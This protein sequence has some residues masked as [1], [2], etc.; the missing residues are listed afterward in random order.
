MVLSKSHFSQYTLSIWRMTCHCV[1]SLLKEARES[2]TMKL[3]TGAPWMPAP[4]YG[5]SL[6]GL[7]LNL[8]VRNI[9]AALP[10]HRA[11]LGAEVV[12]SDPDFAVLRYGE[13]GWMLHADH[14]Y[15]EHPLHPSL[16]EDGPR[17]VGAELRLHG[18]DPDDDE[19][20]YGGPRLYWGDKFTTWYRVLYT[21]LRAPTPPALERRLGRTGGGV[22]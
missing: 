17:G 16:A 9:A 19:G 22:R 11:V 1:V 15:L 5:H 18:R 7:T 21:G 12:Y 20:E 3:R 13:V 4:E 14:T 6:S 10:F 8:L 2:H